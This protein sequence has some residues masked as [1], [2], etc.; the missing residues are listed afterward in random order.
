MLRY[1]V[2][3]PPPKEDKIEA[4]PIKLTEIKVEVKQAV[5]EESDEDDEAA[6]AGRLEWPLGSAVV[7]HHVK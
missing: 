7:S 6:P 5:R 3:K 4:A 1:S 2:I